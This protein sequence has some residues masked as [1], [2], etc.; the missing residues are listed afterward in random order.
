MD[1][2]PDWTA[3][4]VASIAGRHRL[5]DYGRNLQRGLLHGEPLIISDVPTD[6]LTSD[7]GERLLA[8]D[9]RSL[10][11]VPIIDRGRITGMLIV[12]AKQPRSWSPETLVY[13]RNIADRLE[14]G[15]ARLQAEAQ[16]RLL[17]H[18]LS[19][20]MKNTMALVQAVAS[21]TLKGISERAPVQAFS[22]RLLALSAAHDVLLQQNWSAAKVGAIVENTICTFA[23]IARFDI[24]GP[25]VTLGSRSAQSLSLLIHELTTNAVKI[26]RTFQR[27]RSSEV[28]LASR[29]R[30]R[31]ARPFVC[32]GA[33]SAAPPSLRRP[34]RVSAQ[35]L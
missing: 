4:G 34:A 15:I 25:N 8:L 17:N 21:Q 10:I 13:L 3:A 18:E 11:N 20:R 6:P 19:H 33:R 29:R 32:A 31:R 28:L 9:I 7:Y 5:A 26:R 23:D 22:D 12:H 35:G 16:Q 1:V 14:A 30:K 27:Y 24:S 2:E